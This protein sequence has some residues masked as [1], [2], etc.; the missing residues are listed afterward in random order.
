[1]HVTAAAVSHE[2]E[3]CKVRRLDEILG[4][5]EAP[6][7]TAPTDVATQPAPVPALPSIESQ[8][9]SYRSLPNINTYENALLWWRGMRAVL[10]DVF[11]YAMEL[12][13]LQASETASERAFSWAGAFYDDDRASMEPQVLSDYIMIYSNDHILRSWRE[14]KK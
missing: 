5:P 12:L 14:V 1:M 10:P 7:A 13:V 3:P 6:H 8:L 4:F 2:P 11:H 9:A